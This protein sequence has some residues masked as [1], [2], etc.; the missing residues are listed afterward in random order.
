MVQT[1][2]ELIRFTEWTDRWMDRYMIELS[3]DY[4]LPFRGT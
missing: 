3:G 1:A 2:P 4:M